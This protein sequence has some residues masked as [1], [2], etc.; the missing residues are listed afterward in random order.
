[1]NDANEQA[2]NKHLQKQEQQEKFLDMFQDDV[3]TELETIRVSIKRIRKK[4]LDFYGYS[5][6]EEAEEWIQDLI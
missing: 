5:F 1:M 6:Q 4:S 2:L 3:A